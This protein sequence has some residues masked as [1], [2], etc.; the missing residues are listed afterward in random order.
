MGLGAACRASAPARARSWERGVHGGGC[1]PPLT[2]LLHPLVPSTPPPP[3]AQAVFEIDFFRRNPKP[4]FLL[5]RELFP[6]SYAPTPAH[7]FLALL[8]AKG[9]LLRCF[10]QNIDSLELQAGLPRDAVIAAHGNFDSA[11]CIRCSA[12]HPTGHVRAA[13]MAAEGNPAYCR[14]AACGGLVKVGGV[15][16]CGDLGS[17]F[18]PIVPVQSGCSHAGGSHDT[19]CVAR[20]SRTSCSLEKTCRSG[21]SSARRWTSAARTC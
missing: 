21:F 18:T 15:G 20:C 17:P 4:F 12:E 1:A 11:R 13:V 6:G 5:A 8:H 10:T 16:W 9:L 3:P 14:D 7:H 2:L 19:S